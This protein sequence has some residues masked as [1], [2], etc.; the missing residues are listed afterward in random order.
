MDDKLDFLIEYLIKENN[1]NIGDL[2]GLY[3]EE[4]KKLYR[5]LVNIRE[6]NSISNEFLKVENEYLQEELRKANITDIEN[7]KTN[8]RTI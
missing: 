8:K 6:P 5:S 1:Q 2:Y 3:E 7:I 4:K